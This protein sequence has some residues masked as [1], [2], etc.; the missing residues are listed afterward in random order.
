MYE[1]PSLTHGESTIAWLFTQ[2]YNRHV[3]REVPILHKSGS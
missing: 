3:M 1:Q 2:K